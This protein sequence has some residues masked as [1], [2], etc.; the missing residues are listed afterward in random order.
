MDKRNKN[1]AEHIPPA[2]VDNDIQTTDLNK[3]LDS[4]NPEQRHTLV[5]AFMAIESERTFQGPLPAPEDFKAYG[6]V[7]NNAPERIL[8]MTEKQVN[9]RI[10][11]E[12][13]IVNGGLL[14]SRRGQW[15][16]YSIVVLLIIATAV[17]ALQGH[18]WVSGI[19]MTAAIGLAVVFVLRQN[20]KS[21][22]ESVEKQE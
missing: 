9:H 21:E 8:A 3:V 17:L 10:Q 1:E 7:I 18:D 22:K 2:N 20:P 11:T 14:E 12:E 19:M 16:G 13:H 15:M 6:E 5:K 4:L